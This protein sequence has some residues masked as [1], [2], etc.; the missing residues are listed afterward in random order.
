MSSA[1][2]SSAIQSDC[3]SATVLCLKCQATHGGAPPNSF[4]NLMLWQDFKLGPRKS[5][6]RLE[7]R[8][9]PVPENR[10]CH[11]RFSLLF[12]CQLIPITVLMY[13]DL[14]RRQMME[15][16]IKTQ[17]RCKGV[18]TGAY[19]EIPMR[20]VT[21]TFPVAR[22]ADAG[23]ARL[24]RDRSAAKPSYE[25]DRGPRGYGHLPEKGELSEIA[26]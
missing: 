8:E 10:R 4:L 24:N 16:L 15:P 18:I 5:A 12:V 3:Q 22:R 14:L 11:M 17:I 7:S 1:R 21:P 6:W 25:P 26:Q 19:P 20:A 13:F 23:Q 9:L 2:R